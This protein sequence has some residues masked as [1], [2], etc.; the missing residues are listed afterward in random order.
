MKK[1]LSILSLVAILSLGTPAM[2]APHGGNV[3]MPPDMGGRGHV[4]HAGVHHRPNMAPPH[5]GHHGGVVVNAGCPRHSYWSRCRAGYWSN[6]WCDY[7]LGWCEPCPP[8][9]PY[10]PHAGVYFP[11]GGAGVSIHF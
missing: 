10:G 2:A 9:P 4:V 8:P 1:V 5:H 3:G 11:V 7:R 6:T